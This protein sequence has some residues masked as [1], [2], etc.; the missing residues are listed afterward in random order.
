MTA[1]SD[2]INGEAS[3]PSEYIKSAAQGSVIDA[4]CGAIF[5]PIAGIGGGAIVPLAGGQTTV[6]LGSAVFMGGTSGYIDYSLREL[7]DGR[8]PDG[9]QA[10]ESFAVG[11]ALGGAFS[12]GTSW[13][14][15]GAE[16][17]RGALKRGASSKVEGPSYF[18]VDPAMQADDEAAGV[19]KNGS[20]IKNPTAKN[21]SDFITV[22]GKIGSKQMSG[23]YMYVVDTNGN[24]VIGTRAGQKMPHPTLIGG[25]N[26]KVKAAGIVEIRGGQI[27]K[28]DNSSGHFKPSAESLKAAEEAFGKLPS[29]AFSPSFQG[30]VPYNK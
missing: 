20:Y 8:T 10:L 13:L 28:I 3:S 14:A 12:V 1:S 2:L 23:Q 21:L 9:G 27:Y 30:Y 11:A 7:W 16:R 5:G 19:L 29:S 4:V 18:K 25:E 15:K 24:I 22:S 26:P 17:V 6:G